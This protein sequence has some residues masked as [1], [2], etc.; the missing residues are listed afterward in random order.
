MSLRA[1]VG[2]HRRQRPEVAGGRPAFHHDPKARDGYLVE[3][4]WTMTEII[5]H[6]YPR[7]PYAEKIRLA[8]GL[9]GLSYG[10]VTTPAWMPKPDLLALTG[11]YR[12][13]PVLQ[14]GADIFCD[15][16]LI[17][18]ALERL[19]P[20]PTLFPAGSRASA[21]TLGSALEKALFFQAVG[22]VAGLAGQAYPPDLLADR[23][24][25]FGFSLE[26][27]TMLPQ[28]AVFAD[29]INA[30]LVRLQDMLGDG[31]PYLLGA[32]VTAADLAAYH[33]LWQLRRAGGDAEAAQIIEGLLPP[34]QGLRPWMERIAALG[35]GNP[36]EMTGA[37]ALAIAAAATPMV[38]EEAASA[39]GLQGFALGEQVRVAADDYGRDPVVGTLVAVSDDAIA[40]RRT[41]PA[42]G[43]ITVHFPRV[44]FDVTAA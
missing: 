33:P 40:L 37:E 41:D 5:L 39:A 34:L 32:A 21:M 8:L 24:A 26:Q 27:A 29:R 20:D 22:L 10:S 28:Q 14:V 16:A 18:L 15:S 30:Q 31:R 35:H 6:H 25:C 4:R 38:P 17:L 13:A 36:R 42:L 1:G 44:G 23:L 43:E 2:Y 11:G 12:R 19:Q 9:K 3:L 7:S